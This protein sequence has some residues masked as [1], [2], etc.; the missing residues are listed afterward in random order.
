MEQDA[1]VRQ[2]TA[3][4]GR[5]GKVYAPYVLLRT[6][7][8]FAGR[9]S[10]SLPD[11]I[12]SVLEAT[13]KEA[14]KRRRPPA[15]RELRA[16]LEKERETQAALAQSATKVF[17]Q[18]SQDD[19]EGKLTRLRGAPT[20]DLILLRGCEPISG[21]RWRLTPLDG[22]PMDVSDYKWSLE[23]ARL[24]ARHCVRAP[25]YTVP[26]QQTPSWLSLHTNTG[27]AWAL[28]REE[29]GI[30]VFPDAESDS[31]LAYYPALGLNTPP[32][33]SQPRYSEDD[34]DDEF[35]Y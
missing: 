8:V 22:P 28:V 14:P 16:A 10:I 17:G 31:A 25:L 30:C 12:R 24:L 2:L 4:F 21:G 34:D 13:Y 1:D 18:Q 35:D 6:A 20:R 29:D 27:T 9:E 19:L 3:A 26:R 32:D 33:Q 15:W 7:E 5:T 23:V 11:E